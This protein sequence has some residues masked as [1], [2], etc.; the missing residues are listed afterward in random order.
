MRLDARCVAVEAPPRADGG[1][2]IKAPS[3]PACG[4]HIDGEGEMRAYLHG[5]GT[6][7]RRAR[8]VTATAAIVLGSAL[9]GVVVSA[10][11]PPSPAPQP[12]KQ[13]WSAVSDKLPATRNGA[14]AAVRPARL[15]AF[16]LDRA[17]LEA[18]LAGAPARGAAEPKAADGG[19]VVS[20]PD[21]KGGFQRFSLGKSDVMAPGLAVK[22][23]EIATFSGVGLDDPDATIH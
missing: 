17:G 12:G 23:P 1:W 7:V 4:R 8:I 15:D 18:L 6:G 3:S 13:L 14:R 2:D 11:G 21:P 5:L 22:H 10:V 16:T 9:T 20:L 19:L